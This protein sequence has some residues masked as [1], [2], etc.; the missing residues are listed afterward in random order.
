MKFAKIE[1]NADDVVRHR[2]VKRNYQSL[3]KGDQDRRSHNEEIIRKDDNHIDGE[4][5]V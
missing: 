5:V 1:L 4:D 2:L 3:F